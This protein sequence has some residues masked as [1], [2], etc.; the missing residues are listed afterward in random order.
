[1]QEDLEY[2]ASVGGIA[3][4]VS[5]KEKE[6]EERERETTKRGREGRGAKN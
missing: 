1:M 3:R 2:Q 4:P 5:K 6:R